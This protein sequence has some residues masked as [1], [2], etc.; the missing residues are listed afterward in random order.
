VAT[1]AAAKVYHVTV[2]GGRAVEQ[3]LEP[4]RIS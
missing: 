2:Q 3:V 4:E 1:R